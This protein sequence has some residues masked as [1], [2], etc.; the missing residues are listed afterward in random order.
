[1]CPTPDN[2]NPNPCD[3]L[4]TSASWASTWPAPA[5][6]R[7]WACSAPGDPDPCGLPATPASRASIWPAPARCPVWPRGLLPGAHMRPSIWPAPTRCRCWTCSAP[8]SPDPCGLQHPAGHVGE[9]GEHLADA[10]PLPGLAPWPSSW[11]SPAAVDLAGPDP[12]PLLDVL[13]AGQPRPLRPAGHVG[14]PG[15]HLASAGPLPDL[16][17]CPSSWCRLPPLPCRGRGLYT[18]ARRRSS[19][20]RV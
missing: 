10:G 8:G 12:L 2:P 16:V 20:L 7:C 17:P 15:E 19:A 13:G 4:A 3:L 6:C 18:R 14:E 11:C 5:R 9:P 1:M